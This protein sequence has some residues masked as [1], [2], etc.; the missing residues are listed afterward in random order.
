MTD[1]NSSQEETGMGGHPWPTSV[2]PF[3]SVPTWAEPSM[4]DALLALGKRTEI[5]FPQGMLACLREELLGDQAREQFALLLGQRQSS[6]CGQEIVVVRE[7]HFPGDEDIE[8]SARYHVRPSRGFVRDVLACMQGRSELDVIVDVHTHPFSDEAWFS[9]V[10]DEDER[11]FCTFL[12]RTLGRGL[13]FASIVLARQEQA[14]RIWRMC[15]SEAVSVPAHIKTQTAVEIPTPARDGLDLPQEGMLARSALALGVDVLR[16]ISVDRLIVLAGVGGLGS[17]LAEELARS[18]FG[19]IGLIDEDVLE[20]SNLNRFAGGYLSDALARRPKVDVVAEHLA[21]INPE[22]RTIC[23]QRN[24]EH[25]EAEALMAAADWILVSTDSH[26]S[27][28]EVQR[29]ALKYAV[30]LI[31]A[32]VSI[33]VENKNGRHRILDQSG[34]VILLRNGDGFCLHCLGRLDTTRIAAERHPDARVRQGL[35]HKGYV[36][37]V[38][39]KEP[40]VMPLN[41]IIASQAVQCLFDQFREGVEHA[42]VTVYEGHDGGRM[43]EDTESLAALPAYC[44]N[45]GRVAIPE[46]TTDVA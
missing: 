41:A 30:P 43:Y 8:S 39:E 36:Q 37:G 34:E 15:G 19:F 22:I 38:V 32:G 5:R 18:G 33:T 27:R 3:L 13:T 46:L 9:G 20:V 24:V 23:L 11:T 16:R 25:P 12:R 42:P 31:S 35:V 7:I 1:N 26:G 28:H 6:P 21:R 44:C 10:D 40:A 17:V 14:G 29:A 45:C 2:D 4:P